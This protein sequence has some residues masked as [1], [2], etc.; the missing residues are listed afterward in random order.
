[1]SAKGIEEL[2]ANGVLAKDVIGSEPGAGIR[3]LLYYE[4]IDALLEAGMM[5]SDLSIEMMGHHMS[6]ASS[7]VAHE[8]K[9]SYDIEV[10]LAGLTTHDEFY[11]GLAW[12]MLKNGISM[13]MHIVLCDDDIHN[14]YRHDSLKI[15]LSMILAIGVTFTIAN[16]DCIEH[17][18][19]ANEILDIANEVRLDLSN[20]GYVDI[21]AIQQSL[22]SLSE[23]QAKELLPASIIEKSN[24]VFS[25][26]L[27]N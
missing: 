6:I 2:L 4:R 26:S 18:E 17:I 11:S 21:C 15:Q 27:V 7:L 1:M 16:A 23:E 22:S 8:V 14:Q 24:K 19:I 10:T 13:K 5:S 20:E 25:F 3:T 12:T 9:G